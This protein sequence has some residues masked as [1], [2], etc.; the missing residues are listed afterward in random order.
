MGAK[1]ASV[2]STG[3][4]QPG[5]QGAQR[6]DNQRAQLDTAV[7]ERTRQLTQLFEDQ[8]KKQYETMRREARYRGDMCGDTGE[9]WGEI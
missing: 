6:G 9:I 1:L 5:A 3:S 8:L 7:E 4:E 2:A